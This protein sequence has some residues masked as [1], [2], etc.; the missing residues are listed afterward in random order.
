MAVVPFAKWLPVPNHSGNMS[1]HNG[2]ILHVQAGN[3]SCYGLFSNP[4]YEA[5]STFWVGKD[6]TLE[7]YVD[8]DQIAWAQ[9]SGNGVFNSVETEG[10][11]TEPLTDAQVQTLGQLYKW[12]MDT[13]G[14]PAQLTDDPNGAGFG[15][16]GMGGAAWGGH[17][18]CPG[19]LRKAQRQAIL[20]IAIGGT[21]APTPT[22]S[23]AG[24]EEM[25]AAVY[26]DKGLTHV[27]WVDNT[28]VLHH[29]YQTVDAGLW[30]EDANQPGGFLPNATPVVTVTDKFTHVYV[31]GS[32]NGLQ[33]L[34]QKVGTT[35]W[36]QEKV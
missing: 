36:G 18:G 6:G 1:A 19:D 8:T 7:Q 10:V 2:L 12:G 9:A 4:S 35:T 11:P 33:H 24:D 30:G 5:S 16:H 21:P 17:T 15:W 28:G 20:D 13:Y 32:G 31:R 29:K 26:A 14:W 34:F 25:A 22:P 23:I 27:W 3:G